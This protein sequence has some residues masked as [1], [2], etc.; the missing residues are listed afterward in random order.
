MLHVTI[1]NINSESY[2]NGIPCLFNRLVLSPTISTDNSHY[3][4]ILNIKEGNFYL[5]I[6]DNSICKLQ[7]I[8]LDKTV[9]QC[10]SIANNGDVIIRIIRNNNIEEYIADSMMIYP[11][12]EPRINALSSKTGIQI[13]Y[14]PSDENDRNAYYKSFF[15]TNVKLI[16][17][18]QSV[19]TI[20]LTPYFPKK[21]LKFNYK[22]YGIDT[23]TV[24]TLPSFDSYRHKGH[25]T[26]T[27][28]YELPIEIDWG[29]LYVGIEVDKCI[30]SES[31]ECMSH[32]SMDPGPDIHYES[33]N[34]HLKALI[35][36]STKADVENFLEIYPKREPTYIDRHFLIPFS[37]EY[38]RFV[39][40]FGLEPKK[41][42]T[43]EKELGIRFYEYWG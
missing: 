14:F 17:I 38:Q 42:S 7:N 2:T 18:D 9:W 25:G 21:C 37:K 6:S 5:P 28:I 33:T 13:R 30:Y 34:W 35:A 26:T 31:Y 41:K 36:F 19:D 40:T 43:L 23:R 32:A 24:G 12:C 1:R 15:D 39:F 8:D 29:K 4:R 11:K 20:I 27:S 22:E 16:D 3:L 10:G